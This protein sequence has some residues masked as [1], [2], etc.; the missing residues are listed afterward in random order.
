MTDH[1]AET[2]DVADR[3]K[4][5]TVVMVSHWGVMGADLL[6]E[7]YAESSTDAVLYA[8]N[9]YRREYGV[10]PRVVAVLEGHPKRADWAGNKS[11]EVSVY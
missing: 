11:L 2:E 7:Q 8:S 3:F 5:Y 9:D 6:S 4:A 10:P 1:V